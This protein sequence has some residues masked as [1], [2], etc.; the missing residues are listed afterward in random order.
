MVTS[1]ELEE[2]QERF[3]ELCE[4]AHD[5]VEVIITVAGVPQATIVPF[6]QRY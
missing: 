4:A 1:V 2:A 6:D 5:G 3:E